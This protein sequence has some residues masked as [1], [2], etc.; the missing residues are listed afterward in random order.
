[1]RGAIPVDEWEGPMRSISYIDEETLFFQT[2]TAIYRQ[3][4]D[5]LGPGEPP[6]E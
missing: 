3:R 4:L 1:M 2:T 6:D 5:A